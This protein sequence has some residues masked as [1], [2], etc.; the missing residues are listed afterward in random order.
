MCLLSIVLAVD[1]FQVAAFARADVHRPRL[2]RNSGPGNA[3]KDVEVSPESALSYLQGRLTGEREQATVLRR[4]LTEAIRWG[5]QMQQALADEEK[6][7]AFEQHK[8]RESLAQQANHSEAAL[9]V[10]RRRAAQL[11]AKIG[12]AMVVAKQH[13][14]VVASLR[15]KLQRAGRAI[16]AEERE[17]RLHEAELEHKVS[18][19]GIKVDTEEQE[20]RKAKEAAAKQATRLRAA[21][22][23][24]RL[25]DTASEE[26][27]MA[28]A[29]EHDVQDRLEKEQRASASRERSLKA[30]LSDQERRIRGLETRE[31]DLR[32]KLA[33]MHAADMAERRE[34][35]AQLEFE[36][37]QVAQLRE[38][39][40][41]TEAQLKRNTTKVLVLEAQVAALRKSLDE[42]GR[43]RKEAEAVARKTQ[44]ALDS[45]QAVARQLSGAVPQLLEQARLAHEARDAEKAMRAETQAQARQQ[46]SKLE[47]Q[48]IDTVRRQLAEIGATAPIASTP[49]GVRDADAGTDFPIAMSG[50]GNNTMTDGMTDTPDAEA[51]TA[52]AG[53]AEL[54]DQVATPDDAHTMEASDLAR[55]SHGLGQLL[56]GTA[57][58]GDGGT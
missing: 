6:A 48:Y 43:A 42:S 47:D 26:A 4:H 7:S 30:K 17:W 5:L 49:S 10:E 9:A 40:A 54:A 41:A 33:A 21:E 44:D 53:L 39:E 12:A 38:A 27:K 36:Q 3:P 51:A 16:R 23:R 37:H 22:D 18:D 35:A 11:E 58:G 20:L 45:A 34:Q 32:Q 13:D 15:Q 50:D 25:A 52:V 1:T 31:K 8:L 55:D 57:V 29:A 24:A 56:R 28:E 46:I 2:R 14:A 19:E